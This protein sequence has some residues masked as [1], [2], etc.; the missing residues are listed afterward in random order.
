M[1][2]PKPPR[3]SAEEL[4]HKILVGARQGT[5][6]LQSVELKRIPDRVWNNTAEI[7]PSPLPG[8]QAG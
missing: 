4:D 2:Y 8:Q 1:A 6:R 5:L 7:T 3:T